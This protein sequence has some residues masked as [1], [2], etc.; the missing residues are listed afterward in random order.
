MVVPNRHVASLNN[1]SSEEISDMMSLSKK[2]MSV[3][4]KTLKSEGFNLGINLG[5][6]GGAGIVDHLHMHVVPR[7]R[8]DTNCM[9]VLA[10][11]KVISQS[12]G[13]LYKIIKKCLQ[14]K[15]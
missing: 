11:T 3:L 13:E 6:A 2:M 4:K 12:L 7:W 15:K 14:K 1:L 8:G 9:P 10:N 5:F